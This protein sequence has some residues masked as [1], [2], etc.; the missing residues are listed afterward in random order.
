MWKGKDFTGMVFGY[1]EAIRP[2]EKRINGSVVWECKCRKC[3]N[4]CEI[5]ASYFT[6]AGMSCGCIKR[7]RQTLANRKRR[8]DELDWLEGKEIIDDM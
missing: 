4:I 5:R 1:L 7:S 6:P 3:G 8:L 2:T